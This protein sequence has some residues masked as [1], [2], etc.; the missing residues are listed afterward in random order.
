MDLGILGLAVMGASLA[1][2]FEEKGYRVSVFN[3]TGGKTEAFVKI[4]QNKD[5]QGFYSIQEFVESLKSPRVIVVMVRCDGVDE[6][7]GE[8]AK[9]LTEEDIVV[10]GGNSFYRDTEK[11]CRHRFRY[12]GCGVSGG[13]EGARNGPSL[14]PGG[15]LSAWEVIRPMFEAVAAKRNGDPCCRWVG[16]G[17]SG[18]FVK[19]VHNGIEYGEMQI[20]ADI[21]LV[22]RKEMSNTKIADVFC[23]WKT[24]ETEAFLVEAME[25]ILRKDGGSLIDR[26]LDVAEQKGTGK[27]T[28]LDAIE[29]GIPL[30]VIG[31]AVSARVLSGQQSIRQYLEG[32]S[33]EKGPASFHKA[34]SFETLRDAM[35][36][37]KT[38]SYLQGFEL[39][40]SASDKNGWDIDLKSLC[41]VWGG[42]CIIRGALLHEIEHILDAPSPFRSPRFKSMLSSKI[43]SL[44]ETVLYGL[45][46]SIHIPCLA[47]ALSLSYGLG[48][49]K[50]SANIIQ[51][52]R[53]YFGAHTVSIDGKKIHVNWNE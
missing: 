15:E 32:A 37:A 2:N 17:G 53:D 4:H 45:S 47:S 9:H 16:P 42:G 22:M 5:I 43:G 39:I 13:E 14:M 6:V 38:L 41:R 21:Y 12:V 10:D 3:R 7:L 51:G 29:Q 8:L 35:I 30:N 40:K 23:R 25:A 44:R 24:G 11:R 20:L 52:L 27:W 36:L 18:H 34:P 33:R 49:P 46:S 31:E 28:V 26:V 1:L 48:T 19:M 50:I